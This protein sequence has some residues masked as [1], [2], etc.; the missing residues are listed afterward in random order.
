MPSVR[1]ERRLEE[2][3]DG[4]WYLEDENDD[5]MWYLEDENDDGMEDGTKKKW[6]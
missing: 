4:M 2:N 5:G 1:R 6:Q 3:D